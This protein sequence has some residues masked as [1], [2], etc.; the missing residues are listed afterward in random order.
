MPILNKMERTFIGQLNIPARYNKKE[1]YRFNLRHWFASK[2]IVMI[3]S[4]LVVFR[5][6]FLFIIPSF[7]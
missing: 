6:T 2:M 1:V 4:Y 5:K 3:V 7:M